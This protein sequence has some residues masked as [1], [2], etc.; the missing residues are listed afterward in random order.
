MA[1]I[2]RMTTLNVSIYLYLLARSVMTGSF[3]FLNLEKNHY[4]SI[5][6]GKLLI[7][8][9]VLFTIA[10]KSQLK[11]NI[12]WEQT[13]KYMYVWIHQFQ[14]ALMLADTCLRGGSFEDPYIY[15]INKKDRI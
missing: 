12:F 11:I 10:K 1:A 14:C 9:N 7:Y 3:G 6:P 13:C 15:V 4:Q 2:A 5:Q 8:N